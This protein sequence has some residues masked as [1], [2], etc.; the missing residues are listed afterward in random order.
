MWPKGDH[1][2]MQYA[3]RKSGLI[4]APTEVRKAFFDGWSLCCAW[5]NEIEQPEGDTQKTFE[6]IMNA[7][8]R[9]G[10]KVADR[11]SAGDLAQRSRVEFL[12]A[13]SEAYTKVFELVKFAL[14]RTQQAQGSVI[15]GDATYKSPWRAE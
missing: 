1:A 8:I 11:Y 15:D 5:H 3:L 7:V 2:A 14:H 12:E 4:E 10:S 13:E 9:Y 6:E